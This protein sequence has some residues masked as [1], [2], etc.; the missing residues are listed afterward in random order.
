MVGRE[1]GEDTRKP[2]IRGGIAGFGLR[3]GPCLPS[4]GSVPPAPA[5][6]ERPDWLR[7]LEKRRGSVPSSTQAVKEL[8]QPQPPVAFGLLKVNPEP[9]MEET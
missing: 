2:A 8:P 3:T 6:G 1:G 7:F 5:A 9:C 4:D